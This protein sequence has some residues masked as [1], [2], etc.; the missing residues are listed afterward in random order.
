[1]QYEG[2][3]FVC[4]FVC[5]YG[6]NRPTRDILL[7]R[8]A[9]NFDLC[10]VLI[11]IEQLGYFSLPHQLWHWTSVY[12][13]L[14]RGPVTLTPIAERLAVEL[15]LPVLTHYVFRCRDFNTSLSACGAYALTDC[16]TH[17]VRCK[18]INCTIIRIVYST[19]CE[20]QQASGPSTYR[21]PL[22]SKLKSH[23]SCCVI[24]YFLSEAL[25][26][27]VN[28]KQAFYIQI[29]FP[30]ICCFMSSYRKLI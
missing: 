27:Y 16:A 7:P 4:L 5:L 24:G 19:D 13:G 22:T 14:I 20:L 3:F 12:N 10:S 23:F 9:A 15:S 11:A 1:M 25:L 17:A 29:C 30:I 2:R 26:K 18:Y 6:V 21:F 28:V 8:R